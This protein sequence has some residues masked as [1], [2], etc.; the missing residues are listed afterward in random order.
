M[1]NA[2]IISTFHQ[3]QVN[4]QFV[5]I[6]RMLTDTNLSLFDVLQ[7]RPNLSTMQTIVKASTIEN[8][9]T[10]KS[11]PKEICFERDLCVGISESL[12]TQFFNLITAKQF[13]FQFLENNAFDVDSGI[14]KFELPK[15]LKSLKSTNDFVSRH[16]FFGIH[17][18]ELENESKTRVL[19]VSL[20]GKHPVAEFLRSPEDEV[21][22]T[23]NGKDSYV[24]KESI[25]VKEGWVQIL[26][27][28]N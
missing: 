7:S 21:D 19:G 27:P 22:V 18:N 14:N 8:L 1:N 4:I 10:L 3:P 2:N 23:R 11:L 17:D 20:N 12:T 24:I 16:I 28:I 25:R 9:L 15:I 26:Q 5:V 6:D 13:T